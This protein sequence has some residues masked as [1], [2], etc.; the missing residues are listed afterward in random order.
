[1]TVNGKIT[2]WNVPLPESIDAR[3]LVDG[4]PLPTITVPRVWT[5]HK[6]RGEIVTR[7]DPRGRRTV[8][9]SLPENLKGLFKIGRLDFQSEGL[10]LLTNCGHLA[11]K[12]ELPS[13]AVPRRYQVLTNGLL[14]EA[15]A[16]EL[17]KG[18]VVE[19]I[20]YRGMVFERGQQVRGGESEWV[21]VTLTEGKNR[22]IR[23]LFD[24]FGV[25]VNRLKRVQHGPYRLDDLQPRAWRDAGPPDK[26]FAGPSPAR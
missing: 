8:W 17:R 7:D 23:R 25:D 10:L 6:P 9:D 14:S 20:Q 3:I 22:E 1:V 16:N 18:V 13:T 5:Y 26:K 4:K 11:R 21:E 12:L 15:A 2:V 24:F 19:G